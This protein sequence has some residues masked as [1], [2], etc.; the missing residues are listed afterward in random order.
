MEQ[1]GNKPRKVLTLKEQKAIVSKTYTGGLNG[2]FGFG[3]RILPDGSKSGG[4]AI[5][6]S[7][8]KYHTESLEELAK[9]GIYPR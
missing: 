8:G 4:G 7:D 1:K 6:R 5:L 2:A 9:Q 3:P